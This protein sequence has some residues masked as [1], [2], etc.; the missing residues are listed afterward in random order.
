MT[1]LWLQLRLR[2]QWL[3][4]PQELPASASSPAVDRSDN[5][6]RLG[7][8][9]SLAVASP[10]ASAGGAL[11]P[12]PAVAKPTGRHGTGGGPA[13]AISMAEDCLA[14]FKSVSPETRAL[15]VQAERQT[16]SHAQSTHDGEARSTSEI[17]TGA[18][19]RALTCSAR[20]NCLETRE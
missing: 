13:A 16:R 19:S 18:V 3:Q 14:F 12:T 4:R 2:L 10:C 8:D 15:I 7:E 20:S 6:A 9:A 5:V 11:P 17:L 1:V